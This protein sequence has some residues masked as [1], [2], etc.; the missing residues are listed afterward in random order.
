MMLA[1]LLFSLTALAQTAPTWVSAHTVGSGDLISGAIDAAGNTYAV[2]SFADSTTLGGITLISRGSEDGFLVKYTATGALAWIKQLGSAG[3]DVASGVALDG[4]G[5]AYV[6]GFFYDSIALGNNLALRNRPNSPGSTVAKTF[7]VCYSPQ[8]APVWAQQSSADSY[9]PSWGS[10]VGT[11]ATGHVYLTGTFLS[12]MSLGGFAVGAPTTS[13]YPAYIARLS[14]TTGVVQALA[15]AYHYVPL[16]GGGNTSYYSP[17]LAVAPLGEVYLTIGFMQDLVC[18]ATRFTAQGSLGHSDVL[19]ARYDAQG[20]LQWAQQ[21]GG[22]SIDF[23]NGAAA[24]ASGNLYVAGSFYGPATFGSVTLPATGSQDGCLIKYSPQ[25]TVQWVQRSGGQGANALS[26]VVLDGGGNPYVVGT[27][28]RQAQFGTATVSAAGSS[29]I[30]V[31]AYTPQGQVRWVQQAGGPGAEYSSLIGMDG[32]GD[33]HIAGLFSR[34]CALGQLT[35]GA[36]E[37]R[38]AFIASLNNSALATQARRPRTLSLHPNPASTTVRVPGL[39]A[40]SRV[41]LLDALGRVVRETLLPLTAQVSVQGLAP[42]LYTLRA[43]NPKGQP[44]VSRLAVE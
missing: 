25:G 42:G 26:D 2:G 9:Y 33:V 15:L 34:T 22:T 14:A 31:A 38:S 36:P 4:A 5:N 17:A 24:D 16:T 7:V 41:Q 20:I 8:G 39:A 37:P 3:Q 1:S 29:D 43:T 23:A 28:S 21:F 18:G 40:G 12:G 35:L 27:F 10:D 11:D 13:S 19:V 44:F 30:A 6:T 32:R